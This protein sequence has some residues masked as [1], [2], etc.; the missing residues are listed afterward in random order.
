MGTTRSHLPGNAVSGGRFN[1]VALLAG[2]GV[3]GVHKDSPGVR[4][5][6]GSSL[7]PLLPAGA[8]AWRYGSLGT[9]LR[10]EPDL[11]NEQVVSIRHFFNLL[12]AST[13]GVAVLLQIPLVTVY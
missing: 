9:L 4:R 10:I 12:A 3:A 11:P 6:L 8:V 5:L 7:Y 1:S 13:L 2:V